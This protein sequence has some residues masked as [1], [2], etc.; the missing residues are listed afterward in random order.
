MN[1]KL[2]WRWMGSCVLASTLAVGCNEAQVQPS[3]Q[4]PGRTPMASSTVS[5]SRPPADQ[6]KTTAPGSTSSTQTAQVDPNLKI[7]QPPAATAVVAA[8]PTNP[9]ATVTQVSL[10]V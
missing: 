1:R 4:R 7:T 10:P 5:W 3:T 2:I 6:S 9:T 8:P